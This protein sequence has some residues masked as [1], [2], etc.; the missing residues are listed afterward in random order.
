MPLEV[1]PVKPCPCDECA[2]ANGININL[3]NGGCC[4]SAPAKCESAADIAKKAAEKE[5]AEKKAV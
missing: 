5:A 1:T 4:T 3:G 2:V